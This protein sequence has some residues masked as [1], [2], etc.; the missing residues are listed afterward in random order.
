MDSGRA[1]SHRDGG[2]PPTLLC[3]V[4]IFAYLQSKYAGSP[5]PSATPLINA[6]DKIMP[7][8]TNCP[9]SDRGQKFYT[10]NAR[11]RN[12]TTWARTQSRPGA[13]VLA[14]TPLVTPSETAQRTAS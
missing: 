6:E 3:K 5:R 2:G 1:R 7:C 13:K 12:V 4:G 14:S 9:R 11:Y 8:S 10:T